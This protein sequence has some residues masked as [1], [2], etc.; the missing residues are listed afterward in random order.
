MFAIGSI[1][2]TNPRNLVGSD[3]LI[4][5]RDRGVIQVSAGVSTCLLVPVAIPLAIKWLGFDIIGTDS[6]Y[7]SIRQPG[8][9]GFFAYHPIDG[10]IASPIEVFYPENAFRLYFQQWSGGFQLGLKIETIGGNDRLCVRAIDYG[11]ETIGDI[12]DYTLKY[13]LTQFLSVP[14]S[15]VRTVKVNGTNFPI[16]KGFDPTLITAAGAYQISGQP[17]DKPLTINGENFTLPAA[18][19]N[20]THQVHFNYPVSIDTQ[21]EHIP[22]IETVPCAFF[23]NI[24][25]RN[26]RFLNTK[27]AISIDENTTRILEI[28]YLTDLTLDIMV[29]GDTAADANAI[30]N[31][32]ASKIAS[33]GGF[34]NPGFNCDCLVQLMAPI[35]L[36]PGGGSVSTNPFSGMLFSNTL[37]LKLANIPHGTFTTDLP[38]TNSFDPR[39]S[40]E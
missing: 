19:N 11:F 2:L 16:P 34:W 22:Q 18:V 23:R 4:V 26:L 36:S 29:F 40:I 25:S 17:I 9:T 32:M 24:E 6:C 13:Q 15:F 37:K 12:T 38:R 5:T 10:W 27:T 14:A 35:T 7:I 3:N 8:T 20:V 33:T 21:N 30:S 39:Y 28:P 31:A 1:D